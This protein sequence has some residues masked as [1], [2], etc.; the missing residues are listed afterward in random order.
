[1]KALHR[2]LLLTSTYQQSSSVG[3]SPGHEQAAQLDPDN[4]LLW[5]MPRQRLEAEA[6]RDS[7]LAVS[8]QLD[9]TIGGG[10]SADVLYQEAEILDAKRGFAPN[11]LQTNHAIYTT[12]TRRSIYLPVVRNALPDVL[13]LFDAADP[14]GVTPQRND[15]TVPSQAL[16]SLNNPFV[17]EQS[18]HFARLLLTAEGK[19]DE[20]R[21]ARAYELAISRPPSSD[22]VAEAADY[23]SAYLAASA[24]QARPEAE[25]RL[26]A[27]QSY[28]QMLLCL[29]E[30]LY[31][32]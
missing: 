17:R 12:S 15:T 19:S 6:L 31:V 20:D 32:D 10:D 16:F 21:V 23:L 30:F 13:A 7:M 25:R 27:W 29:N 9:R 1:V 3:L 5:R 14:N 18:Q 4:R 28:C 2:Q 11:R 26:S 22:E 8:G 24:G